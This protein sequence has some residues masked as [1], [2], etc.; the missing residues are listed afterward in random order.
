MTLRAVNDCGWKK[1]ITASVP[2]A[3]VVSL[4]FPPA[5]SAGPTGLVCV[6]PDSPTSQYFASVPFDLKTLMQARSGVFPSHA[7]LRP[8]LF[9]PSRII[10]HRG[11][12]VQFSPVGREIPESTD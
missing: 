1:W 4:I 10:T 11:G 5:S 9:Q 12:S 8:N 2:L 3:I 7:W 6:V